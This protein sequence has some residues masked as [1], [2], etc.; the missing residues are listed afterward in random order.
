[1]F[2]SNGRCVA[3]TGGRSFW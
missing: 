1:M 2:L 3:N